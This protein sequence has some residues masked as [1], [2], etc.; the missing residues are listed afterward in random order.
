VSPDAKESSS[1]EGKESAERL[2]RM[3]KGLCEFGDAFEG[4]LYLKPRA[5]GLV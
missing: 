3:V 2:E 5:G 1:V 4:V